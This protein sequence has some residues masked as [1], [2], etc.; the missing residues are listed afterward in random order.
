MHRRL[1]A[2]L[3]VLLSFS[4]IAHAQSA[5][6]QAG[7]DVKAKQVYLI[8]AETGT[9][10]FARAEDETVPAASLAKLM[11]MATVFKALA[12]GE[13]TL[14]TQF[15]VTEHAWRTGG[16]P[17][18]TSTMFAALKSNVRVEDLVRGVIIQFA[19][20]ACI[21][22]GEGIA[23]SETAFAER[24]TQEARALGLQKSGFANAT[25][26]PDPANKVTMREMVQLARHLQTTY[27]DYMR[28]YL[29]PEFEWNKIKQRNRNPLLTLN[30]GV[31]G[32]VTGFSEEGGYSI[33]AAVN[34]D[35]K[36]LVLAMGGMENDKVRIEETRRII[37]WALSSFE[38]R[39]LFK[40][41]EAIA[42]ASV[43][44][45]DASSVPLVAGEQ[46]DVFLP[47]DNSQK[48]V[49]RVVYTWPVRAPVEPGQAIGT[50]KIWNDKQLLRE[51]PVETAGSVGVGAL[52]SRALDALIELFFFW[53]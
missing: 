45:G 33:V 25:G 14:D 31:T 13:I 46:V 8:E 40:E 30:I 15:P 17:S 39:T 26:L 27:P 21:I 19:N 20:D 4:S 12:G 18:R 51:V 29:E 3:I 43:Y 34:R 50:L 10:L 48:L 11:T 7:F 38:R 24:M 16:A 1:F 53:I 44:G 5:A 22:L 2:A 32:F 35:G 23:G 37:E 52:R 47:K 36:H 41:G 49:A 28:Y 42:D 6:P 9:V